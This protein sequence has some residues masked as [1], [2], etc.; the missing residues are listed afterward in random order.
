M[1][2]VAS[3]PIAYF[4]RSQQTWTPSKGRERPTF[5]LSLLERGREGRAGRHASCSDPSGTGQPWYLSFFCTRLFFSGGTTMTKSNPAGRAVEH[6]P[7]TTT[8]KTMSLPFFHEGNYT[9]RE[10]YHVSLPSGFFLFACQL[11]ARARDI[12][13]HSFLIV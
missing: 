6:P 3:R 2:G 1:P 10:R 9:R 7:P 8:T 13:F 12:V 11:V 5:F 4:L